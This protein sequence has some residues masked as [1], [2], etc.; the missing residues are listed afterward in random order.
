M[1]AAIKIFK[2]V[3]KLFEGDAKEYRIARITFCSIRLLVASAQAVDLI[4]KH[5]SIIKSI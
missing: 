2:H 3:S 5:G 4:G 1:D